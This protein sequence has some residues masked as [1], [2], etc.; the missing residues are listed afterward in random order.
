MKRGVL[1]AVVVVVLVAAALVGAWKAFSGDGA[2]AGAELHGNVTFALL[3]AF[4]RSDEVGARGRDM[5]DGAR[6]AAE[7]INA[8]G[9]VLGHRVN[10]EL[11]DD[12][13]VRDVA[14][15][16]AKG[17]LTGGGYGGAVG[18]MCEEVA[19][20]EAS[21]ID[22]AGVPFLVTTA[23]GDDIEVSKLKSTYLMNGTIYQQ[24]LSAV[25]WMNYR[26]SQRLAIVGERSAESKALTKN[27]IALIDQTPEL[28][29][30]QELPVGQT[31]M[32]TV[33]KAALRSKPD[34]VLW[35]GS[36]A[37]GGSLVKELK[38]LGFEGTFTGT[39]ASES[40]A[41][42]DAAGPGGAE[43]AFVTATSSPLN[44]PT[45]AKWRAKFK[46]TYGR[47]PGLDALQAYD[48]VRALAQ[49]MRQAK[50]TDGAKVGATLNDL[51][52]DFV[53]FL[54]VLRFAR[55]H[56][57]LYDNR[58]V[59]VVKDDAFTWQRSLRTDSLQ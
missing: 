6:M 29:S 37:S 1:L 40:Q 20:R 14:Y 19:A 49:A 55:D 16:T 12:A 42:L 50:T 8:T 38:A 13:C 51:D 25:Y 53:T 21:V 46:E 48:S 36:A 31:D 33:A 26:S 3:G 18:G 17:V 52:V 22:S 7:E 11:L 2:N 45:A 44:T 28:L 30:L 47:E 34:F 10:L 35:T 43:G 23:I 59:L 5:A 57:L 27:V 41:F 58:V 4:E 54:G 15:E 32:K 9:G 39:A 24:A 56:T